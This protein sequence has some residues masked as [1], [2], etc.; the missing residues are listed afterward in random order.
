MTF[1]IAEVEEADLPELAT[2]INVAWNHQPWPILTHTFCTA[3]EADIY[4]Y[5]LA[6]LK[7]GLRENFALHFKIVDLSTNTIVSYACWQLP[8]TSVPHSTSADNESAKRP[9]KAIYPDGCNLRLIEAFYEQRDRT[10]DL[11]VDKAQDYCNRNPISIPDRAD[12]PSSI[13]SD[14]YSA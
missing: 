3:K 9:P 14:I 10:A 12:L 13:E 1:E 5:R 2:L 4:E 7:I 8:Q 11:H 6:R